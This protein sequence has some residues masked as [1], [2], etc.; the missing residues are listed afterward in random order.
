M[1]SP[2]R[3]RSI[4]RLGGCSMPED[5]R[6]FDLGDY[7]EVKDRIKTFYELYGQGRL[8]AQPAQALTAPDGKQRVVVRALAYRS[9]DDPYPAV[10]QSWMELPGTTPYTRGSELE[11]TETS[12]IGRAIGFL[13]I[14]IDKSIASGNEVRAKS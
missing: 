2:S 5:R 10:G 14:L 7:V 13:G 4:G 9:P 6:N 12:A 11:N 3:L 1:P 8:V